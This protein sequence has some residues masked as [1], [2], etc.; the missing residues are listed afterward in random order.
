MTVRVMATHLTLMGWEC[1][2]GSS[3][4][5]ALEAGNAGGGT[6]P[7]LLLDLQFEVAAVMECF[8]MRW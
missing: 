2:I 6:I 8:H 4:L 1:C 3:S 7:V 5:A